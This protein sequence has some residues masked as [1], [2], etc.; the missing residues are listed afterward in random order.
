MPG[1]NGGSKP[2]VATQD[3]TANQQPGPLGVLTVTP[4]FEDTIT[5]EDER[6]QLKTACSRVHDAKTHGRSDYDALSVVRGHYKS[7]RNPKEKPN[8]NRTSFGLTSK[9]LSLQQD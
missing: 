8:L 1:S 2:R 3:R 5:L 4:S 7:G 9:G 6:L